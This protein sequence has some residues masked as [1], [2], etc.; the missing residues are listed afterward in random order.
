M[1]QMYK[2][3]NISKQSFHQYH[4]RLIRR[5]EQEAYLTNIIS[6]VRADHPTMGCRD[7]YYFI[8]PE[9]M[10]RDVF[11]SFCRDSG[12]LVKRVKNYRRTT[13]SSG[14]KRF[15]NLT[16]DLQV[17][18]P[19]KLWVSDITYY[20]VGDRFYYLTFIMDKYSRRIIGHKTS[21]RLLTTHST[22]PALQMALKTRKGQDLT[23][24]IL[25]SDGGGQYYAD[26]FLKLTK[27]SRIKNSMCIYPWENP[28]AERINGVIKNNYLVHRNI[29]SLE[30]LEKEVDRAVK[31]YN[32]EKPH[33]S[34]QRLSPINFESTIFVNGKRNGDEESTEKMK[35]Y[36]PEGCKPS[37][38]MVK[39][40]ET[41]DVTKKI[42]VKLN[43]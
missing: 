11:E 29:K 4:N 19:N 43:L 2:A 41:S 24:V 39:E 26:R 5:M 9:G 22:L 35:T 37:G 12:L 42:N 28:Y 15:D 1:N 33:I 16:L 17:N 34:L 25:H 18:K 13:D 38:L 21:T 30:D 8:N 3:M 27:D 31:L 36:S 20:Q 23:G 14:V 7:M 40:T 10:G 6:Q 32:Q